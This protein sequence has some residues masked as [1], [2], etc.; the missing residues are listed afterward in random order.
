MELYK[1][2]HWSKQ[3]TNVLG[4]MSYIAVTFIE[5]VNSVIIC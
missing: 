4:N 2:L 3:P 1:D 5:V